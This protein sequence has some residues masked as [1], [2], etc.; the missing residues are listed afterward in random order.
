MT[1]FNNVVRTKRQMFNIS[2]RPLRHTEPSIYDK[3]VQ[4]LVMNFVE[5]LNENFIYVTDFRHPNSGWDEAIQDPQVESGWDKY[6]KSLGLPI[7]LYNNPK[8]K[9]YIHFISI[10]DV[11]KYE[12]IDEVKYDVKVVLQKD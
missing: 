1:L 12:T 11:Q 9:A 4:D 7:S 10:D 3:Q 6:Q 8:L 2:N 5:M